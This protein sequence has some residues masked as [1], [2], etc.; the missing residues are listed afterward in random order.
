MLHRMG[1]RFVPGSTRFDSVVWLKSEAPMFTVEINTGELVQAWVGVRAAVRAGVRKGVTQ[2]VSE[3]AEEARTRHTF[4]NR[5]TNLEKSIVGR[6]T[7]NRTSVGAVD[8]TNNRVGRWKV[9]N[10]D[11]ET[12]GAQFGEIH[13]GMPYAS[14]V[15]NGTKP[16]M[17]FPK[18]ATV[19]SWIPIGGG[20]RVFARWVN[21]PGSKPYPFMSLGYLK[22]E[23]VMIREIEVGVA[24]A[25]AILDR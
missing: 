5:T 8:G 4:A 15:E 18:R 2:G 20:A 24:N 6:L 22:C 14:F 11:G 13:A 3:G 7:G 16:H 23:R 21:H 12:D 9:S 1:R 25:Q 17:I 10:I 19:L